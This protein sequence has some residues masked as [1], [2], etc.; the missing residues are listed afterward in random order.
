MNIGFNLN[1]I[2][3]NDSTIIFTKTSFILVLNKDQ[4][5]QRNLPKPK[6]Q[7]ISKVNMSN[8]FYCCNDINC[9][10]EYGSLSETELG[11][12]NK[13]SFDKR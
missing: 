9:N 3:M 1:F 4:C 11:E 10:D 5:V 2:D 12:I 8:F 6:K 7:K 13:G